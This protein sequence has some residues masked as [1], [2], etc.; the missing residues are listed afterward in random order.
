M[1]KREKVRK[2]YLL[3]GSWV[4]GDEY[5]T[6]LEYT[7]SKGRNCFRVRAV[8]RY[9]GEEAE[10][11]DLKWNKEELTFAAYWN[12]TGRLL[13]CRLKAL[14]ENRVDFTYT[15][16]AQEMWHRKLES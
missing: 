12:S 7:V 16:T 6:E 9:D 3:I 10:V 5:A 11:Y 4:N 13:K 15:Y 8:D 1:P 2:K 14:S